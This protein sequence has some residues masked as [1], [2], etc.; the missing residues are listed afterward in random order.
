M[1]AEPDASSGNVIN[2]IVDEIINSFKSLKP[3]F[4]CPI[5]NCSKPCLGLMSLKHHLLKV[6]KER[7]SQD[8]Q[9]E[10]DG[11]ASDD[12]HEKVISNQVAKINAIRKKKK[13]GRMRFGNSRKSASRSSMAAGNTTEDDEDNG[14]GGNGKNNTLSPTSAAHYNMT[15]EESLRVA[16][17]QVNSRSYRVEI[18]EPLQLKFI[19]PPRPAD[20]TTQINSSSAPD[21]TTASKSTGSKS[22]GTKS[23]MKSKKPVKKDMKKLPE[24]EVKWF[25]NPPVIHSKPHVVPKEYREYKEKTSEELDK[26]VEYVM[27]DLDYAWLRLY[28]S[29]H[30]VQKCLPEVSNKDF[31]LLMDR[32]EKDSRLDPSVVANNLGSQGGAPGGEEPEDDA[33]CSICQDGEANNTNVILFCDMC[34]LPVHQECYGVPYIPEGQWVCRKCLLSPAQ[35]VT[36]Q[37]CPM[38]TGAFKQTSKNKWCHVSCAIWIPEVQFANAVFLEPI[39]NL[40][41][42]PAARFKLCCYICKKRNA[43]ACVQCSKN[44]CFTAFHI[45][46]GQ[47]AGLHI[48]LEPINSSD[49]SPT[50]FN[51]KKVAYCDLHTPADSDRKPLINSAAP[52]D[53]K[54]SKKLKQIF[55]QNKSQASSQVQVPLPEISADKYEQIVGR[56]SFPHKVQFLTRLT[57]YWL[58][59]RQA[60]NGLPLIKRLHMTHLQKQQHS[61]KAALEKCENDNEEIAE[62]KRTL[63][64]L[65]DLRKMFEKSRLLGEQVKKREKLKR[66]WHQMN[67]REFTLCTTSLYIILNQLM[68]Q[69]RE[70]DCQ[71]IFAEPVDTSLV[72]DYRVVVDEPMDLGTMQKKVDSMA[73]CTIG[74]FSR[75]FSLIVYNCMRY[76]NTETPY[77][78]AAVRLRAMGG[79]VIRHAYRFVNKLGIDPSTG[80]LTSKPPPLNHY[81]KVNLERALAYEPP[82]DRYCDHVDYLSHFLG[83]WGEW[84]EQVA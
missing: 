6:H 11:G 19:D 79:K 37:L 71:K 25:Q 27:D 51:V 3:P 21:T 32:L 54:N 39:E 18:D 44:N 9:S 50:L 20:T 66:E 47:S 7:L 76:N 53:S 40:E 68:Q 41:S 43:G 33:V 62:T 63:A 26:E 24:A 38:K 78:K 82:P 75:D 70:L 72:M 5:D 4:I 45:A 12:A 64:Y 57:S 61:A 16:M 31:E 83:L 17:F 58:L 67:E 8:K 42:I 74:E 77:F 23:A 22:K 15:Y 2:E 69:M 60:L 80:L 81:N 29:E 84:G 34:N 46:C 30:R 35:P 55:A 14:A 1:N 56:V 13:R 59:R 73:Y 28:N 52:E 65:R 10:E 48:K 36:C 49:H